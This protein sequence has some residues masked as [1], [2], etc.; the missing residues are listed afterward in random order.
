VVARGCD[1][2]VTWFLTFRWH[3][4]PAS[5]DATLGAPLRS[6]SID[7]YGPA[8]SPGRAFASSEQQESYAPKHES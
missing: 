7:P 8:I 1:R 4:L 3:R 6:G 5:D 2:K